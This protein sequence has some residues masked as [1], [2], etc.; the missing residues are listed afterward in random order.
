MPDELAGSTIQNLDF[1][2]A[3][4]EQLMVVG[5]RKTHE[6]GRLLS[7]L[8]KVALGLLTNP[9]RWTTNYFDKLGKLLDVGTDTFT[10]V[11]VISTHPGPDDYDLPGTPSGAQL[12]NLLRHFF[13]TEL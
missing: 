1:A 10:L 2:P 9:S 7:A 8:P 3:Q 12:A 6:K 5:R 4:G 13:T 11:H